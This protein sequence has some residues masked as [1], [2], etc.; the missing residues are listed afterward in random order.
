ME[1]NQNSTPV[2]SS[3]PTLLSEKPKL[4]YFER[5]YSGRLNRKNYIVGSTFLVLIPLIC[6][7][8]VIFNIL[9]SPSAFD[10]SS[11]DLA[12]PNQIQI[13]TPQ[14]SISSLLTTPANKLWT[15]LGILFTILS[16]PYLL[17]IQIRRLHDLNL[18]GWLWIINFLP[19][20]FVKSMFSLAEF[21]HPNMW[22]W[23]SNFVSFVTGIFSIYI[24]FWPGTNGVNKYGDKPLSRS[25]SLGNIMQIK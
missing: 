4:N 6:F 2:D 19:L 22:F 9:L 17:S 13:T 8:V 15:A 25:T 20:L 12:N 7:T 10:M 18:S 21:S 1:Q 14:L 23:I 16:L 5:L 3:G 24:S 11:L